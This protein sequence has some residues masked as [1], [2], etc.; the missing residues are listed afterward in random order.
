ML[1]HC[2]CPRCA[3]TYDAETVLGVCACGSPL[4]ASYDL[5]PIRRHV[6]PAAIAARPADLW[7]YRELLPV[8]SHCSVVSLGEGFTPLVPI[9]D[10]G[11]GVGLPNLVVKDESL[12]SSS[13]GGCRTSS[14]IRPA[15]ASG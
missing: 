7:R 3:T 9:R 5:D 11:R 1:S 14:S 12:P 2:E 4:L 6:T 15:V 13:A 8:G 10:Y